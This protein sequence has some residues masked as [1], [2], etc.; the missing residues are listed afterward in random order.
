[1][2]ENNKPMKRLRILATL[3][4]E[5]NRLGIGYEHRDAWRGVLEMSIKEFGNLVAQMEDQASLTVGA[6]LAVIVTS[7]LGPLAQF[8]EA[9]LHQRRADAYEAD[10]ASWEAQP[11]KTKEGTWRGKGPTRGQRMLMIRMS[12]VLNVP[13]PGDVTRGEA[14]DWIDRQGGN[15]N[16]SKET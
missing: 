4:A 16:Y 13:L 3:G 11:A 14:A 9:A 6:V 5:A 10:C 2:D 7:D 15:P 8:G 12:R 1:M